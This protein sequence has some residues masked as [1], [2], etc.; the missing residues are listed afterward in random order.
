MV[1]T[2]LMLLFMI[3]LITASVP[4]ERNRSCYTNHKVY[5]RGIALN[6]QPRTGNA[7]AERC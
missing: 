7:A 4:R 1:L 3:M 5:T 2:V 6:K